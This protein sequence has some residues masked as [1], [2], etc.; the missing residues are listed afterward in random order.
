MVIPAKLV[1]GGLVLAGIINLLPVVGMAGAAWLRS[2]YGLEIRSLDLEILLRHRAV[3]FGIVGG[4][5]LV[6]AL[7]P[8]LRDVAVLVAGASMMSFIVIALLVG[9]YGPAI[10]KVVIVDIVGILALVPAIVA[11]SASSSR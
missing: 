4:L 2:L 1:A 8:G 6:A 7:R 10:R 5:L 3:L 11:R 9:G